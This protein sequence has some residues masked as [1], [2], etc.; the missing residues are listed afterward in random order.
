MKKI[1]ITSGGTR[2]YIDDVRVLTNISSGALGAKI[3]E[4]FIALNA[5]NKQ[6][7]IY[8]LHTKGSVMP[9]YCGIHFSGEMFPVEISGANSLMIEMEKLVPEMDV[10]VHCMAV[11]DF[12]F[13]PLTEKL[14]S[15][16]TEAFIESLRERIIINPKVIS[17][18]KTWNPDV[19]LVSFKFEVGKTLLNLIN[20]AH[21]SLTKNNGDYVVANDKKE[22]QKYNQH[23]AYFIDADKNY[24]K[25]RGKREIAK[26]IVEKTFK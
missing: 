20:I 5:K 19:T 7:E 18:I 13:M 21:E 4:E 14:K 22:M 10:V 1:L 26:K 3:A 11:S 6:C 8:Y 24:E 25:C 2:E 17:N 12:G 9:Q 16:D 23:I 15:D